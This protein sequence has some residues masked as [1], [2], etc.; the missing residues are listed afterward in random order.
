MKRVHL[1]RQQPAHLGFSS[2]LTDFKFKALPAA[3]FVYTVSFIC[4]TFTRTYLPCR[5]KIAGRRHRLTTSQFCKENQTLICHAERLQ[6]RSPE[7]PVVFLVLEELSRL[8][9]EHQSTL[10]V[11]SR[12]GR[13]SLSSV[14][15][16][17]VCHGP[18]LTDS[19]RYYCCICHMFENVTGCSLSCHHR[20]YTIST[21]R[22]LFITF[23]TKDKC[24]SK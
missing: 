20:A 11:T 19:Y 12:L 4:T 16:E 15:G 23:T 9:S 13:S 22:G 10:H 7:C 17:Q 1:L 6:G 21:D 8:R 14:T 24:A 3:C 5:L 2:E 18:V